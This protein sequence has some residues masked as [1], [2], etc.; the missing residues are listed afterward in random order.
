M[1]TVTKAMQALRDR[2]GGTT[3]NKGY[4]LS[5]QENLVAGIDWA[6]VEEDLRHGDGDELRMKFK[7]IH[8]S[9]ALAVNCFGPFQHQLENFRLLGKQGAKQVGFEHKLPI[10]GEVGAPNID[11]WIEREHDVV[12]IESKL[13]EYL[14][15]KKAK[16]SAAYKRLAPPESDPIWWRVYERAKES[17]LQYL[18]QAQLIKHYFG[19]NELRKKHPE[20]AVPTLLYIFWEPLDWQDLKECRKHREEVETFANSLSNSQIQFR[21]MSYNE[22][23]D[24]WKAVPELAKH[25]EELIARYQVRLQTDVQTAGGDRP[26]KHVA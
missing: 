4:T 10:F 21:A 19:L 17:G 24:Q 7:A 9:A 13:L 5:P 26:L 1:N 11:V 15:P 8:S 22:L 20:G 6:L 16:F 25:A 23:W 2:F 18:D 12:A 3:D 14:T